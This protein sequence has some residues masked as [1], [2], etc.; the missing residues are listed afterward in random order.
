MKL[1]EFHVD[2]LGARVIRE[3]VAIAGVFPTV[4][5]DLVSAADAAGRQHDGLRAKQLESAALALVPERAG[6]AIAVREQRA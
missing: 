5:R 1:H 4:A 2:Q 6:D 3:R